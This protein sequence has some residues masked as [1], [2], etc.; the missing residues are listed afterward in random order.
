MT[1]TGRRVDGSPLEATVCR[2]EALARHRKLVPD[3]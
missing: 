3:S 2:L 1:F